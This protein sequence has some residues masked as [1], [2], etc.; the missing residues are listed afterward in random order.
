VKLSVVIPALDEA[1][2]I[3]SAVTS[4]AAEGVEVLVVDGGS[5]DGTPERARASG[6]TVLPSPPGRARQLGIGVEAARGDVLLFLHADTQLLTG[7]DTAVRDALRDPRTCGGAFRLRFRERR[8]ALRLVEW[9]ARV[10]AA[11]FGLPYG[12]QALFVRRAALEE[13]GGVPQAPIM[14]DLDLVSA[15][16]RRGRVVQLSQSAL[17]S[18]RRYRAHGTA[19]TVWRNTLA[20][21]AWALGVDRGRVARWYHR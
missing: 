13:I 11:L 6:A 5:R 1:D 9:S 10:R 4:A 12:D 8:L 19:R 20:V 18:A 16:H 17:T 3:A 2:R 7:W 21:A 14:E 15:L